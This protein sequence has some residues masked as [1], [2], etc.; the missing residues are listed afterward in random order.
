[1]D[2]FSYRRLRRRI[3]ETGYVH[4][5]RLVK[6]EQGFRAIST[7]PVLQGYLRHHLQIRQEKEV[8]CWIFR[9]AVL[10]RTNGRVQR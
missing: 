10:G 2:S 7:R 8:W 5:I 3:E 4:G 6:S 1:M 9:V